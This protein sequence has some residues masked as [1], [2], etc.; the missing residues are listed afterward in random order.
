MEEDKKKTL[1]K[2]SAYRLL[3]VRPR[4]EAELRG[5]LKEKGYD[6][7]TIDG[8]VEDLRTKGYVDDEKFARFWVESRMHLNP[9]GDVVLKHELRRKGISDAVIDAA[10]ETKAKAYNEYEIALSMARDRFERLKKLD[11]R[12]ATKRLYDFM[13]RRGFAYETV[14]R[15]IEELAK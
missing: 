9:V 3:R 10:L 13:L 11:R 15:V 2:N 4:S 14:R 6:G 7:V 8:A 1:A 12:K 5:R